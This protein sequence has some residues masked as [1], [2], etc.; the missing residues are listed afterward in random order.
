MIKIES[1]NA[2]AIRVVKNSPEECRIASMFILPEYQGNGYAKQ[3]LK[4]IELL[5][6]EANR[7]L[8]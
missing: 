5:Y 3:T 8:I 4:Q 1:K 6:P 2:G 7:D